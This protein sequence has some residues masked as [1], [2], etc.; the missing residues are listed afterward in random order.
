MNNRLFFIPFFIF[1]LGLITPSSSIAQ[2]VPADI[3]PACSDANVFTNVIDQICWDCFLDDFTLYGVGSPPDGASSKLNLPACACSDALGVPE[4]G[5]PIGYWSPQKVNEVVTTPWCSP[6][7]GGIKLQDSFRGMGHNKGTTIGGAEQ[8][9]AFY[10][11]HYFAYPIMSMLGMLSLP[12]CSGLFV[13]FDLL[14]I[15]EIDPMWNNDILSLLLNPESIIFSTPM[16]FAWCSAD[17]ILTTADNQLEEFY[18]CAGCD[19]S[20]YPLTGN[21]FPQP[22][23]V[24]GSSLITQRVLAS[25]HRKGL[26]QKTI[27]DEAMC[28]TEY[29]PTIPRSQYKFSMMWPVPESTSGA[30]KGIVSPFIGDSSNPEDVKQNDIL[31]N[32]GASGAQAELFESCCHPM[33][34][35][36]SR[37]CTPVGGRTRPGKDNAYIYMIWN[38]R[39]CCVREIDT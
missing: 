20:L 26:A 22:D 7:L 5:F 28:D 12:S 24:A 15:S 6:S 37:W 3:N 32:A 14:Y 9:A 18:G 30:A 35:S 19:G 16:A 38:Y 36:T 17:C 1:S 8:P 25:L 4:F 23:P 33:G 29:F 27:G 21:V 13:D 2:T 11:Y 39:N 31:N 10:Q 34:M